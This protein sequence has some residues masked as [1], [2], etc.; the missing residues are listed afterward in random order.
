MI[1]VATRTPILSLFLLI[2]SL[3]TSFIP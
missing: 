1:K 2:L 3:E